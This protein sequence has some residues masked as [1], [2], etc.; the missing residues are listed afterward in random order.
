MSL[1]TLSQC[2][3]I[4]KYYW[5]HPS[6]DSSPARLKCYLLGELLFPAGCTHFCFAVIPLD[7]WGN[8]TLSL[9]HFSVSLF[10]TALHI[11]SKPPSVHF[12]VFSPKSRLQ[13]STQLHKPVLSHPLHQ[14]TFCLCSQRCANLKIAPEPE[15]SLLKSQLTVKA[16]EK[17]NCFALFCLKYCS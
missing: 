16:H 5:K 10:P 11:P 4:L 7:N 3:I 13:S 17:Y 12:P 9:L 6:V 8:S 2:F 14:L 1:S 15:T